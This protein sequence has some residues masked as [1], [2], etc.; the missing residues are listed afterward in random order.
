MWD[1]VSDPV[2]PRSG[3]VSAWPP[4]CPRESDRPTTPNSTPQD[5]QPLPVIFLD[6]LGPIRMSK[7]G[8]FTRSTPYEEP[9]FNN[10]KGGRS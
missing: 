4:V 2:L 10:K 5:T 3:S 6:P 8:G 1:R 7:L 9:A